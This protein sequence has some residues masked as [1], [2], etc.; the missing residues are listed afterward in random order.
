LQD[1]TQKDLI[2]NTMKIPVDSLK[3][4]LIVRPDAIGDMVLTLPCIKAIKEKYPHLHVTVMCSHYNKILL[5]GFPYVDEY[6]IDKFTTGEIANAKDYLHYLKEI[7]SANYDIAVHFYSE[8]KEVWLTFFAGIKYQIG[9]KAKVGLLPVF[10]K[11][12]AYLKTFDQTKHVVEYNF[13]LLRNLNIYLKPETSLSINCLEKHIQKAKKILSNNG[14]QGKKIIGIHMGVGGGNKAISPKKFAEFVNEISKSGDFEF[15]ITG[16]S[17][18]EQENAEEFLLETKR[19]IINLVGKT[20]LEILIGVFSHYSLYA[21]VDTGPFHIAAALSVPQLAVFSTRKVKPARWAP[22][23]NRHLIIR[24]S[25]ACHYFCPHEGCDKTICSDKISAEQMAAQALAVL[26][27]EGVIEPKDQ[28]HYWFKLGMQILLLYCDKSKKE[29]LKYKAI[30]E[31]YNIFVCIE[32]ISSKKIYNKLIENDITIIHN[33][34]EKRKIY[35]KIT[36]L[37]VALKL[38]NSPLIINNKQ[39]PGTEDEIIDMYKQA[40]ESMSL[41]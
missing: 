27:G 19:P 24:E 6:I 33:F 16:Y 17:K 20:S 38:F 5:D 29:V 4:I 8:T 10:R 12:G 40:F 3:K 31:G 13:Q 35:L 28:F 2:F 21:G 11:Y 1:I 32:P 41:F 26:G 30:L 36:S 18:K 25:R 39:A 9:D 23:R 15:C 34:S 22:W 7:K 37:I 14:W